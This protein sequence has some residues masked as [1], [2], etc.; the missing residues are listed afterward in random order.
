MT[1][2]SKEKAFQQFLVINNKVC[3]TYQLSQRYNNTYRI[4]RTYNSRG[5]LIVYMTSD[6]IDG[7]WIYD[8][9]EV[10]E[11]DSNG[12]RLATYRYKFVD[13]KWV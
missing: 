3:W 6:Y 5:Y 12:F 11:V 4:E 7:E 1:P 2:A 8:I 9:K 10:Y 13:G